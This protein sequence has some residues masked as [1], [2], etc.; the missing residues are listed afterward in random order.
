MC[1]H[2]IISETMLRGLKKKLFIYSVN[3]RQEC[4]KQK[5]RNEFPCT[6]MLCSL[7]YILHRAIRTVYY[8]EWPGGREISSRMFIYFAVSAFRE[9]PCKCRA[10]DYTFPFFFFFDEL[11]W[12]WNAKEGQ[13]L[14]MR[15]GF[16]SE[17]DEISILTVHNWIKFNQRRAKDN[18]FFSKN[19]LPRNLLSTMWF[20]KFLE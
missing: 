20:W 14:R 8:I 2:L 16:T 6:R 10:Y 9:Y 11:R 18:F 17:K 4:S 5:K 12:I 3:I 7:L 15:R 19:Y 13:R 1:F